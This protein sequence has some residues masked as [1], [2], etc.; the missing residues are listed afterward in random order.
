M[1][2]RDELLEQLTVD[3]IISI[4]SELGAYHK[5]PESDG[6]IRFSNICH[7]D[8]DAYKL[9][10]YDNRRMFVC[11]NC[12][13]TIG[14]IFDLVMTVQDVKFPEAFRYVC[15]FKGISTDYK[16]PRGLVRKKETNKDLD[17]LKIHKFKKE[18]FNLIHLPPCSKSVLGVY[19]DFMP[20]SWYQEGISPIIAET[21]NI[22]V[23]FTDRQGVIPHYDIFGELVG[24]RCRNFNE[25][26]VQKKMKYMP[27]RIQ[28]R[29]Y[30]YPMMY[31]LYGIYQ[32]QDNIR[33]FKR[34][35]IFESEKSVLLYGSIYG[36]EN[37]I[38]V[39]LCGMSFH[40][41]Q[42]NLLKSLGVEEIIMCLDKQ[43]QLDEM[44]SDPQKTKYKV[45]KQY[46]NYIKTIIK[47]AN[48][49]M[50]YCRFSFIADWGEL[51]EYKDS[52][53]DKGRNIWEEF[54][55]NRYT[56]L[57]TEELEESLERD[58]DGKII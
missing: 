34:V 9:Y 2:D 45:W 24:I 23:S 41:Y 10:Y 4:M 37:N 5:P 55:T 43:Y 56:V 1:I 52:P 6:S 8:Y 46:N 29:T 35:I 51:I 26:L 38:A 15:K 42:F 7:G 11:Y 14:T 12:C 50:N 13:G 20:E 31:N 53:I 27:A 18:P 16:K 17:F 58:E 21:F 54:Y 3:D 48:M 33:R 36:Q 19:N 47:D 44:E 49:V 57:D 40:Q 25:V 28:G 22:K 39:A 30:K 32:N